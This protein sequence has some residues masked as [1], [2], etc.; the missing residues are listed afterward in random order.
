MSARWI[1]GS[2]VYARRQTSMPERRRA[3]L[4]IAGI[5]GVAILAALVWCASSRGRH[6]G[7]VRS[8]VVLDAQTPLPVLTTALREGDARALVILFPKMAARAGASPR[9]A[10][11]A[12]AKE[13]IEI[14]NSMRTGFLRFSG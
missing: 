12:E 5:V 9:A 8:S 3:G 6:G 1:V 7:K 2:S 4:W 13:Y 10:T 14:L 11:D